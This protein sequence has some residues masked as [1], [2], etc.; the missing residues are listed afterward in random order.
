MWRW[1]AVAYHNH[2]GAAC[3]QVKEWSDKRRIADVHLTRAITGP[4]RSREA[5]CSKCSCKWLFDRESNSGGTLVDEAAT[6]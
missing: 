2:F 5:G 4:G 1:A 6:W 3:G